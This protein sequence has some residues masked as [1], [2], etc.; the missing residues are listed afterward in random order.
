MNDTAN[1]KAINEKFP[2]KY[3]LVINCTVIMDANCCYS[4]QEC[5]YIA[6]VTIIIA[7]VILVWYTEIHL[8]TSQF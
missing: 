1:T 8:Y 7:L 6:A 4:L 2:L 5:L 3:H